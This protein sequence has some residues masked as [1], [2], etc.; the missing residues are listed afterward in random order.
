MPV[1][2]VTV[3]NESAEHP[4]QGVNP[5]NAKDTDQKRGHA[6]KRIKEDR[7]VMPVHWFSVGIELRKRWGCPFVAFRAGLEDIGRVDAGGGV[8]LWQYRVGGMAVGTTREPA[9][10]AETV[11]FA[12]MALH[13]GLDR[14]VEDLVAPHHLGIAVA[15]Q[16]DLGMKLT[17]GMVARSPQGLYIVQ[18]VAVVAR[19]RITI[20]GSNSLSMA[21]RLVNGFPVMALDALGNNN[22]LILF[23]VGVDMDVRVTVGTPDTPG[24]V[25]TGIVFGI[26]P[27]MAAFTLNLLN[28]DLL[29]HVAGKVG[30][31]SV[32]AGA[33]VFA[34]NRCGKRL[35]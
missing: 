26:L 29:F 9:G 25:H 6:D 11:A 14:H 13:V 18:V 3:L 22:A 27:F 5:E 24:D 32:A 23:P 28:L 4:E 33:S 1:F 12:V 7:I 10:R 30:N 20:S 17:V 34:M 31:V 21:R 8:R 2:L 16:A 19:S 15:L 35:D